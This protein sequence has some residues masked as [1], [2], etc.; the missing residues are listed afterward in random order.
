MKNDGRFHPVGIENPYAH[1]KQLPPFLF[2]FLIGELRYILYDFGM[3]PV[4]TEGGTGSF[5]AGIAMIA[6]GFWF[7]FD[8]VHV[9]TGM[10]GWLS[11]WMGAK[12]SG[13]WKTTS[14]GII[15]VPFMAGVFVLFFDAKAI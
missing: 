9:V 1:T 7:L 10:N 11:G 2:D 6:L 3:Q 13:I 4:G 15:F 8:S 12:G 5:F 14:T